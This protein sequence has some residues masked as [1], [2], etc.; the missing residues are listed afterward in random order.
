M[1][2]GNCWY[3]CALTEPDHNTINRFRSQK[4]APVLRDIFKQIVLLAQEGLV[5]L[6]EIYVDGT[7]IEANANRYTFV[8]GNAIKTSREKMV[9]QL[10]ELWQYA[11]TVAKVELK[12]TG[13]LDFETI[14]AQKVTESAKN[15]EEVIRD[16][17]V[18]KKV[19]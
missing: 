11:Q 6:K 8:G 2:C 1:V 13:P 19:K 12:D 9:K 15:I 18:P 10:D 5:S 7:K 4:A 3:S 17:E 14:D 16:K